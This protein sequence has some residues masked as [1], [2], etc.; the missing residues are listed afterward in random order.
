MK[1]YGYNFTK[2]NSGGLGAIIHEPAWVLNSGHTVHTLRVKNAWATSHMQ[3]YLLSVLTQ[4]G[5]TLV[6][7]KERGVY[8]MVYRSH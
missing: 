5:A 1:I 4:W 8:R 6:K 3:Q 2:R 7:K